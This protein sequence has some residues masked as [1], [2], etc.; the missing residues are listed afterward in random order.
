MFKIEAFYE[1]KTAASTTFRMNLRLLP[2]YTTERYYVL[3]EIEDRAAFEPIYSNAGRCS[4]LEAQIFC[5]LR[6]H[7]H[8]SNVNACITDL[9]EAEIANIRAKQTLIAGREVCDA[10]YL[11]WDLRTESNKSDSLFMDDVRKL[12]PKISELN[13]VIM[14]TICSIEIVITSSA[15]WELHGLEKRVFD[16]ITWMKDLCGFGCIYVGICDSV[17][18]TPALEAILDYSKMIEDHNLQSA[19]LESELRM[20]RVV[21]IDTSELLGHDPSREPDAVSGV[22]QAE[23]VLANSKYITQDLSKTSTES[24]EQDSSNENT[25]I[26]AWATSVGLDHQKICRDSDGQRGT[27]I[28]VMK[29]DFKRSLTSLFLFVLACIA[30]YLFQLYRTK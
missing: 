8:S 21:V 1:N 17:G 24:T 18:G 9:E 4:G 16:M 20:L 29:S 25:T 3:S 6:H 2:S 12:L 23:Y 30:A 10:F 7:S 5:N 28:G 22:Y 27:S 15:D 14:S 26:S 19:L 13:T 11:L